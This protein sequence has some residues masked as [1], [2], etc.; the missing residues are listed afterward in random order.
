MTEE[1]ERQYVDPARM[2]RQIVEKWSAG[3]LSEGFV[4]FPKKLVRALH[5][6]F[7]GAES[8]K[9]IAA[10]LA[11][12]DFRRP[13]LTRLPSLAFLAFLAGLSEEE[14][15][16]TLGRLQAAGYIRIEGDRSGLSISLTGLLDAIDKE[17]K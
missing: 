4:P 2:P 7:T 1:F 17:S 8:A 13:N 14:F 10:V 9:D 12:V 11:I 5:R 15:N 3:V 16:S 6:I